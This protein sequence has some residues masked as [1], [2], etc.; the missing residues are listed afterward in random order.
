MRATL[1][2]SL[3]RVLK[4]MLY[5]WGITETELARKTGISQPVIHR[6]ASGASSNPKLSTLQP[7]AHFF[8]LSVSQLIGDEPLPRDNNP[9]YQPFNSVPVLNPDSIDHWLQSPNEITPKSKIILNHS[10]I[11]AHAFATP[12]EDSAMEP[13][14]PSGS[15]IIIDPKPQYRNK[16]F[17]LVHFNAPNKA[18]FRQLLTDGD[19]ILF[20]ALNSDFPTKI[21]QAGDR[22]LGI[23]VQACIYP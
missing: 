14:F 18:S 23:M 17:V 19:D 9:K 2:S 21:Q 20:K 11:S 15:L 13:R 3:S 16:D 22:I 4:K 10:A 12:C 6:I 7:L 5:E 8:H 1:T